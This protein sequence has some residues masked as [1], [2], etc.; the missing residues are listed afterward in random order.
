VQ[1]CALPICRL[2]AVG[3]HGS[4]T[5]RA[6]L[7]KLGVDVVVRGECEEILVQ[8][9]ERLPGDTAS[10]CFREGEQVRITG[11]PHAARFTDLP[12]LRWPDE[13]VARHRH[14]HHRFDAAPAAPGA[15]VEASRG[16]PYSCSFCAKENFRDKYRRRPVPVLL[17]EIDRLA[18]QGVEYVYFV[19]EIFLP[20]R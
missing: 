18:V 10:V 9:A 12:A 3:P 8:L 13:W 14:H 19:D 20:N 1:T 15:E 5:P 17:D 6:A 7:R 16:C 11:G 4:T 2:I